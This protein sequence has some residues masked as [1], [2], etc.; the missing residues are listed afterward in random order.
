MGSNPA[1][2][3]LWGGSSTGEREHQVQAQLNRRQQSKSQPNVL[4]SGVLLPRTFLFYWI[5]P[6][7]HPVFRSMPSKPVGFSNPISRAP[8]LSQV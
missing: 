5:G 4:G 1:H 8:Q 7:Y 2:S 3:S 6:R